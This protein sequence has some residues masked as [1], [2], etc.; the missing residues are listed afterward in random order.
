MRV[1][2]NLSSGREANLRRVWDQVEFMVGDVRDRGA[3]ERAA[4]GTEYV[5]HLAAV[6]SIPWSVD[7]PLDN[8]EVNATGTLTVLTAAR[9][10]GAARIIYASSC[11]VYGN[12]ET[13]PV[14]EEMAPRP[15]SPYAAAKLMG[16]YYCSVFTSVYGLPTVSLRYF[17]CFGPRQHPDSQYGAAIPSFI[18][19][20]LTGQPPVIFGDG[21]QTRDF[22]SVAN[23][24]HANLL[25]MTGDRGVGRVFN[26]GSGR[27]YSLLEL[28]DQLSAVMGKEITP[29][30]AAPRP[31][32]ARHSV[33]SID[34]VTEAL[35]Y[36][37]IR[38]LA[39]GLVETVAWFRQAGTTLTPA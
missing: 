10:A 5:F 16:E 7:A 18:A 19:R 14:R 17:N 13:L 36:S 28:L 39:E 30:F 4:R 6:P 34:A 29:V 1:L 37:P 38:S 2:D 8:H 25:A 22:I 3:V 27:Q 24:V 26:V 35:G 11:S 23:V 21:K 20:I 31:G 15:G 9:D 12:T 33:A 32:E